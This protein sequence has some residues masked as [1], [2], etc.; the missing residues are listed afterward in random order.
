MNPHNADA[1]L[2][3]LQ[4]RKR[5]GNSYSIGHCMVNILLV[6]Q[7]VL[8]DDKRMVLTVNTRSRSH[9]VRNVTRGENMARWHAPLKSSSQFIQ[10]S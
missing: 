2:H 1:L 4:H 3:W 9:K 5:S 7:N 6:A 10:I 8:S